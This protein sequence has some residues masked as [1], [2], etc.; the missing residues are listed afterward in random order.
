LTTVS[1]DQAYLPAEA[2]RGTAIVFVDRPAVSVAFDSV[3]SSNYE[4]AVMATRHLLE[5]GHRRLVYVGGDQRT[6]TLRERRRGCSFAELDAWGVSRS[7]ARDITGVRGVEGATQVA[8]RMLDD[9]DPPTAIL[10]AHNR[11]VVG[12]IR[13]L[14]DRNAQH[15]VAM[16]GFDHVRLLDLLDPGVTVVEQDPLRMGELAAERLLARM[17]HTPLDLMTLTV[18]TKLIERGSGEIAGPYAAGPYAA[19]A[20]RHASSSGGKTRIDA[21]CALGE[22]FVRTTTNRR[23]STSSG[24]TREWTRWRW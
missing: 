6:W 11:M 24:S 19:R 2:A 3:V 5:H 10:A 21:M 4:G 7:E 20:Q 14:H 8:Y 12:T 16:V 23:A 1:R 22:P 17:A 15:R 18:P 9:A 13:A